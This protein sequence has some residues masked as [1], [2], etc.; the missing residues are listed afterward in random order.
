MVEV[1]C[2]GPLQALQL[3]K[4]GNSEIGQV[5]SHITMSLSNSRAGIR[6]KA[7]ER[8]ALPH[9][10]QERFKIGKAD[11]RAGCSLPVTDQSVTNFMR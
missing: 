8:D 10:V 6:C 2:K 4:Q 11:K 9:S 1:E 7:V 3:L 5:S